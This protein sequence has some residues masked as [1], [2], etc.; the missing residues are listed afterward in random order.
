MSLWTYGYLNARLRGLLSFMTRADTIH[1]LL[2]AATVNELIDIINL[3]SYKK[4]FEALDEISIDQIEIAL[5]THF[6]DICN[7]LHRGLRGKLAYTFNAI[8]AKFNSSNLKTILRGIHADL[9]RDDIL[10]YI[11]PIKGSFPRIASNGCF[12]ESFTP[13]AKENTIKDALEN[14]R[15][16]ELRNKLLEAYSEYQASDN[17]LFLELSIDN[18]VYSQLWKTVCKWKS[19][20]LF[21]INPKFHIKNLVGEEID[22]MNILVILRCI[23]QGIDPQQFIIPIYYRI[24]KIVP[25]ILKQDSIDKVSQIFSQCPFYEYLFADFAD[26]ELFE[27]IST[28]EVTLPRH[29]VRLCR[30]CFNEHPYNV[31]LLYCFLIVKFYEIYDLR[32]VLAGKLEEMSPTKIQNHLILY[33]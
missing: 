10:K 32:L 9:D 8:L 20:K 6:S 21:R 12:S 31:A 3:T 16:P 29:H 23:S 11:F 1:N 14:I 30:D 7:S 19:N 17:L 27:V 18:F 28:L 22:L 4:Y 24:C 15:N 5:K 26:K 33:T 13:L 2:Q 25:I